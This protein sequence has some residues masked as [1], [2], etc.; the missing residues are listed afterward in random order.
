[1]KAQGVGCKCGWP[2]DSCNEKFSNGRCGK[3]EHESSYA[4]PTP[5]V[6]E[7]RWKIKHHDPENPE[8]IEVVP[9]STLTALREELAEA[10]RERDE[11]R[12]EWN[13]LQVKYL[14]ENKTEEKNWDRLYAELQA[15]EAQRDTLAAAIERLKNLLTPVAKQPCREFPKERQP[16]PRWNCWLVVAEV[17]GNAEDY[18]DEYV[19]RVLDPAWPC[20]SCHAR[21]ALS[22]PSE[23][24][25]EQE[26]SE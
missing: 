20:A 16:H 4:T 19:S 7:E 13:G 22:P 21:E 3:D 15:A 9:L 18:K 8:S 5:E 24:E 25:P 11:A 17:K 2:L 14:A 23:P 26:A 6:P 10:K 1:M 12:R